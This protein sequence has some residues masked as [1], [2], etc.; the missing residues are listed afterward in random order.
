MLYPRALG[1]AFFDLPEPLQTFHAVEDE[2]FYKG[3][4]TV[5]HGNALTRRV[6][7]SGGMPGRS[8]EMPFSFRATRDG[9]SEIWER[10]F[11]GHITRSRQW[12]HAGDV[13]AERVGTSEFRMQPTVDGDR[14][15]IPIIGARGFGLPMPPWIF[16][17]AEGVEGVTG[18]GE[19]TFDV[20]AALRG[21][22]L[23]I[24]YKGA[25]A[26]A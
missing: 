1:A 18:D 11:D 19:I 16:S 6:A 8:G 9:T 5:T 12:L 14:L 2:V 15:R 17:S 21:L 13:L 22:G 25:L 20:H 4:V 10:N 23:V 26:P 7:T 3:R 24:R